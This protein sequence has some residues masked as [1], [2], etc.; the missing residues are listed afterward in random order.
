MNNIENFIKKQENGILDKSLKDWYIAH[1]ILPK[2]IIIDNQE[3]YLITNHNGVNDANYRIFFDP[4]KT[5]FG[6]EF[7][8]EIGNSIIIENGITDLNEALNNM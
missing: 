3:F 7:L 4:L 1:K 6:L 8:D 5:T 2:L